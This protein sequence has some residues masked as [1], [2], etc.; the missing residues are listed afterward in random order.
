MIHILSVDSLD[1]LKIQI[2]R[3]IDYMILWRHQSKL[4][5]N[6]CVIQRGEGVHCRERQKQM[7]SAIVS[8]RGFLEL[9]CEFWRE[10]MGIE[11]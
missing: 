3:A 8:K 9:F 10:G 4:L 5:G 7:A 6:R 1:S 11:S 2:F